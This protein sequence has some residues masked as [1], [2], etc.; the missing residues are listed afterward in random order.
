MAVLQPFLRHTS[1]GGHGAKLPQA[2]SQEDACSKLDEAVALVNTL[3]C[4]VVLK[5]VRESSLLGALMY[6]VT[7][8]PSKSHVSILRGPSYLVVTVI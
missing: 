6:N 8:Y 2:I 3:G 7:T 4:E 1:R 5:E